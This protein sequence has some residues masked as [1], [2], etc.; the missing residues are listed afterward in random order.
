MKCRL[1]VWLTRCR[2]VP[3]A[4]PL[5]FH[6]LPP[7]PAPLRGSPGKR[8]ERG[9]CCTLG[10]VGMWVKEPGVWVTLGGK[11]WTGVFPSIDLSLA[12]SMPHKARSGVARLSTYPPAS[13]P[14]VQPPAISPKIRT[15]K[16]HTA[17]P[18]SSRI[19]FSES[20]TSK[21]R[22]GTL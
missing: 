20:D 5:V 18:H 15:K 9:S 14:S 3:A 7:I 4:S 13:L 1:L 2:N 22:R 10:P 8:F 16:G 21:P 11:L 17:N 12:L 6:G 19:V